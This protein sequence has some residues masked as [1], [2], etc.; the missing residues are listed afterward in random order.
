MSSHPYYQYCHLSLE[1]HSERMAL[2]D[3][4]DI[5]TWPWMRPHLRGR[6]RIQADGIGRHRWEERDE[7]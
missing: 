2:H 6:T 1:K 3:A 4:A 7:K 5:V